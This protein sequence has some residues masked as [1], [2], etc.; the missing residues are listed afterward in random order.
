MHL[1]VINTLKN[2]LRGERISEL[3]ESEEQPV[4]IW[5]LG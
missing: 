5:R 2:R 1:I 4:R 3:G